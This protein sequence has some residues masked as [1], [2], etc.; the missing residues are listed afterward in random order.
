MRKRVLAKWTDG[1]LPEQKTYVEYLD[2]DTS[3]IK[4]DYE[5]GVVTV[6]ALVDGKD[7]AESTKDATA[8]IKA[9]LKSTISADDAKPDAILG[10]DEVASSK[11]DSSDLVNRLSQDAQKIGAEKAD[12]EKPR[13]M[14]RLTF[15]LVPDYIKK[16]AAKFRPI[17]DSW[18]KKYNLD[19]SF[20]LAIMRQ[21]SSF[22]PRARSAVGAIGLM[23]IM[24]RFAGKEVMTAVSGKP[25][26][27]TTKYLYDT[28]KNIMVGSTYI[29]LL[30]DQYFSDI[31]D[32][33]KRDYLIT[34][35]YN[36]GPHRI[37]SAIAKGRLST[38]TPASDLFTRLQQI[39]PAETSDYLRKVTKYA[40]EF[41]G[42]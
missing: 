37:K 11:E 32:K 36:W 22:N 19:P 20:V 23:Q 28:E 33:K 3:R 41:R 2:Q 4:V 7:Q 18:A 1:M 16:R 38:R 29:Q 34:C 40:S 24:P 30:R 26:L 9:A 12:D 10:I 14:Y 39:A 15:K 25:L 13:V 35:S 27:P 17:V 5:H 6:E 31:K 8:K 42:E 21:E